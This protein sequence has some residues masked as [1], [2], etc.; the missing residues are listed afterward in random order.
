V[1]PRID[2]P[3]AVELL[4]WASRSGFTTYIVGPPPSPH[5]LVLVKFDG[6]Y[7]DVAHL[8]GADRTEVA[9]IPHDEHANIWQPKLVTFHYYGGVLDALNALKRLPSPLDEAARQVPYSPPRDGT[10]TPLTVADTERSTITVRPPLSART[11]DECQQSD[12][13]TCP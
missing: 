1:R 9:R 12:E 6:G 2:P 3:E 4:R 11:G 5:V 10:P 7:I 8:R 13:H